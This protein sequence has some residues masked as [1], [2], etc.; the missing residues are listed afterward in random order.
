MNNEENNTY[1][2]VVTYPNESI[3][4]RFKYNVSLDDTEF[5]NARKSLRFFKYSQIEG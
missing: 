2:P 3:E 4:E 5:P 1:L